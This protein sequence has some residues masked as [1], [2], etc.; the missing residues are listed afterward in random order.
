MSV[1]YKLNKR[2]EREEETRQRIVDAAVTLHRELGPSRTSILALSR[3]AGVSRPTIYR[4]FPDQKSLLAACS[5][6]TRTLNPPPTLAAW[7]ELVDPERRLAVALTQVFEYYAANESIL[8]HVLRDAEHDPLVR[9]AS[10]PR[11]R[12]MT[13]AG[14]M[15]AH[16]WNVRGAKKRRLQAAIAHAIAFSTWRSLV[17]EEGLRE[18][19]A[20]TLL[21]ALVRAA[22]E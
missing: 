5:G 9:D 16:P 7:A 17:R 22:A 20:I 18:R 3:R 19:E 14:S 8:A 6:H 11:R 4:H 15:L 1:K 12:Y 10:E 21:T 2:A 13:E